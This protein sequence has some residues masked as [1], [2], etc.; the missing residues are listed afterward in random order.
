MI[1]D[2][3]NNAVAFAENPKHGEEEEELGLPIERSSIQIY[4]WTDAQILRHQK[5][6]NI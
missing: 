4:A 5:A 3:N 2:K 1:E 6:T